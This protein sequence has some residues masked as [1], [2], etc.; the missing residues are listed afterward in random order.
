MAVADPEGRKQLTGAMFGRLSDS[1]RANLGGFE[2]AAGSASA[3][4]TNGEGDSR[5]D[6]ERRGAMLGD[7]QLRPN[8]GPPRGDVVGF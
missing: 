6:C 2:D 5:S 3:M 4:D 1:P 8:G 7:I